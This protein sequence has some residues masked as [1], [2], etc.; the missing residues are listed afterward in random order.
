[1][2]NP[3]HPGTILRISLGDMEVSEAAS[4]LKV[5][6]PTLSK[7]INGRAGISAD[8]ALRLEAFLGNPSEFWLDLQKQYEL[9]QARRHKRPHIQPM[10]LKM[11]TASA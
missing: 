2:L 7:I 9:A 6:R 1:M 4:H 3:A 8:M 10:E 11:R 5:S